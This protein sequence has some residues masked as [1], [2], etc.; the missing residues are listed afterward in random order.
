MM[1]GA[2]RCST[3]R[4][5]PSSDWNDGKFTLPAAHSHNNC[6]NLKVLDINPGAG[7]A[8]YGSGAKEPFLYVSRA[9]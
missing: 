6:V 3:C 8:V 7:R 4:S 9:A 5:D 1:P 2:K